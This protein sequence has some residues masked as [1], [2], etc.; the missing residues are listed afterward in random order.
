MEEEVSEK[1][2]MHE[3]RCMMEEKR[4]EVDVSNIGMGT[5]GVGVE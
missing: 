3:Y 5:K 4:R 1:E 2:D